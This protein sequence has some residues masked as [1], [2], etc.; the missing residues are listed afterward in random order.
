MRRI[1][2][3]KAGLVL[4]TLISLFAL[5]GSSIWEGAAGVAAGGDLPGTGLYV[6]T[7]SFPLNTVVYVTNLE[8]GQTTRVVTSSALESAPG[9]LAMLSRDAAEAI[10]LPGRSLGRIRMSQPPDSVAFSRFGQRRGGGRGSEGRGR[11]APAFAA[12]SFLDPSEEAAADG[13]IIDLPG[14][15]AHGAQ[16]APFMAQEEGLT[17]GARA[18]LIPEGV[19]I[20]T[21]PDSQETPGEAAD[22]SHQDA[23]SLMRG[24]F[25][26]PLFAVVDNLLTPDSF[27]EEQE[28]LEPGFAGEDYILTLVPAEARPPA[29]G[30]FALDPDYVIAAIAPGHPGPLQGFIDPSMIIDPVEAAWHP[31]LPPA[32]PAPQAFAPPVVF[33]VPMI[34]RLQAGKYYLQIAAY[35]N[36]EAV[37]YELSRIDRIDSSL[38][39]EVVVMRGEN[40][41]HGTVYQILIGPLNLGESGALLHRFRSTTHRDAFIRAG[42]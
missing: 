37:Q 1:G 25:P 17:P 10:G 21:E 11:G 31:A 41:E 7:N 14:T 16:A 20:I 33:P 8:N 27:A 28:T 24:F 39:R 15:G 36:P 29:E 22:Q 6:A 26:E 40:P 32:E 30:G 12:F 4:C 13:G 2:M 23:V 42:S 18:A 38:T 3:K 19:A 34:S 35:S 9:L 5:V